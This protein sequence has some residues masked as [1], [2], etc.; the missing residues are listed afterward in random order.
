MP[1]P[2]L[3]GYEIEES[4]PPSDVT[5]FINPALAWASGG[6]VST[7]GDTGTFMRGYVGGELFGGKLRRDQRSW[8]TGSSSPPGPGTN[9]AGLALF[10][11]TSK[12]GSVYG[13]TGSFPG[14]RLF[15]ASSAD[16]TRSISYVTN[17]Q[18]TE[19]PVSDLIRKSQVDAVC[20]ALR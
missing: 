19:G 10:K 9:K 16:G 6:I 7:L 20:H 13:H 1:K 17:A 11:Y 12:C 15:F 5:K 3:R 14:Y 2:F 8:V 18:I 4:G